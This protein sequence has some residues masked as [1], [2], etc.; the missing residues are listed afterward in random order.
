MEI[1]VILKNFGLS[2]KEIVVYLAFVESGEWIRVDTDSLEY[3][4]RVKK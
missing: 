1:Q 2:E 3:T 4:D